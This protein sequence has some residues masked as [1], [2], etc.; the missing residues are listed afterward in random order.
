MI[1]KI[2]YSIGIFIA[3]V[4]FIWI[5]YLAIKDVMIVREEGFSILAVCLFT[6]EAVALFS[7]CI[8]LL[9]EK[10]GDIWYFID[11]KDRKIEKY[12]ETRKRMS[13]EGSLSISGKEKEG[14]LSH[15][16]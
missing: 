1:R 15:G 7:F 5:N 10:W 14:S 9:V 4:F 8:A 12:F 11:E 16:K 13:S 3:S 2:I 6:I